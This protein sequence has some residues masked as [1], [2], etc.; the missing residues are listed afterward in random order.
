MVHRRLRLFCV[1]RVWWFL[2]LCRA[3]RVIHTVIRVTP[4]PSE[5]LQSLSSF[6]GVWTNPTRDYWMD[7]PTVVPPVPVN[8]PQGVTVSS[9]HALFHLFILMILMITKFLYIRQ[10]DAPVNIY[11]TGFI[12]LFFFHLKLMKS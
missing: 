5:R 9:T 4:M 7:L 6:L 11:D 1:F 3:T 12:C 10:F 8:Q 2:I